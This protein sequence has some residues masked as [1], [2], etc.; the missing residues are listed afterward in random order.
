MCFRIN[1][2]LFISSTLMLVLCSELMGML[3]KLL[4][5]CLYVFFRYYPCS[6]L[7]CFFFCVWLEFYVN[8]SE[9][10][11]VWVRKFDFWSVGFV[12][13][14]DGLFFI[15]DLRSLTCVRYYDSRTRSRHWHVDTN[16]N[17]R[18]D[19]IHCNYMCWCRSIRVWHQHDTTDM[20]DYIQLH[21]VFQ[22]IIN[23]DVLVSCQWFIDYIYDCGFSSRRLWLWALLV[24]F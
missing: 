22:I 2:S 14:N 5:Q 18:N 23:V 12:E 7:W 24:G 21:I 16:N 11:V 1:L 6:F 19:I 10:G 3:E 17:L 8:G 4:L 20:C 9:Y 15:F 13:M